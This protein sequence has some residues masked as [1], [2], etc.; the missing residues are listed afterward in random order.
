MVDT[1]M[2]PSAPASRWSAPGRR[3]R[4][5]WAAGVLLGA[6]ALL[7]SVAL[8]SSSATQVT[9]RA[10]DLGVSTGG[11]FMW[12]PDADLERELTAIQSSGVGWL[13][14]DVDWSAIES[15]RGRLNWANT[16]RIVAAAERRGMSV[17]A[18]VTYAPGWAQVSGVASGDTHGQ[19]AD[20]AQFA[21]FA[22]TAASRYA[23]RVAAWEVWNEPNLKSF[24]APRPDVAAYTRLLQATYPAIKSVV[25][26]TPV[27]SGGLAPAVDASDGSE[28]SPVSFVRRLYAAGGG[29]SLDA[30]AVHP[31]SYPA[32]PTDTSTFAWNTFQ[33]LQ[34]MR[35]LMVA[36]GDG[37]KQIWLTEFGAPT[38]TSQVSVSEATQAEMIRTGIQMARERSWIGPLFVYNGRD[39]GT[40]ANNAEENFGL[41]RNNY[42]P[43]PA[44]AAVL[45]AARQTGIPASGVNIGTALFLLR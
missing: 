25:P 12:L 9:P 37:G 30:L 23:N 39:Y 6:L 4:R 13:R 18:I 45:D 34:L 32:M 8:P 35:D 2:R 1:R 42:T 17:L 44:F 10:P 7:S 29:R 21:A 31:Y 11:P 36:A 27:I 3:R 16:D 33:R 19:P 38:G 24:W 14:I 28:L 40:D 20:P 41:V 5:T 43:K 26:N 15:T 22:R